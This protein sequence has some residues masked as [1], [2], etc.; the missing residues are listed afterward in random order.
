M[1]RNDLAAALALAEARFDAG[2]FNADLGQTLAM[3]QDDPMVF[4]RALSEL[5]ARRKAEGKP[6]VVH[7]FEPEDLGEVGGG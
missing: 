6:V 1:E 7:R 3:L 4:A 2:T 5:I